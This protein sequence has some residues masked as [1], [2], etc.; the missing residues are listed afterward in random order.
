MTWVP[1][2]KRVSQDFLECWGRKVKWVQRVSLGLQDTEDPQEDQENEASK[3][4]RE[5]VELWAHQASLDLLVNL[6][7]RVPQAPQALH[8]QDNL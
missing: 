1:K 3:G 4:R 5:M 2:E 8:P 6:G 7:V